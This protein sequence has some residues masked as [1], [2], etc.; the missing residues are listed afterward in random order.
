MEIAM[1]E[2]KR[3]VRVAARIQEE[4]AQLLIHGIKDPRVTSLTVMRVDVTDDLRSAR[5]L[6]RLYE[7]D[8]AER[9]EQVMEGLVRAT[10]MIRKE[11]TKRVG[12]RFAPEMRFTYDQG[13]DHASRVEQLLAEV[14]HE[15]KQRG[16]D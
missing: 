12:L 13:Q 15:R 8:T 10:G 6:V 7:G 2:Q 5:I 1:A 3:S 9:R 4:L 11:I 16:G 14:E